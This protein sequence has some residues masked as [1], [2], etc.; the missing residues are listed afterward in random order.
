MLKWRGFECARSSAIKCRRCR[1]A[2]RPIAASLTVT[3]NASNTCTL[4]SQQ[5]AEVRHQLL[6]SSL[7]NGDQMLVSILLCLHQFNHSSFGCH[8]IARAP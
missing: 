7:G 5:Q 8:R 6:E 2:S 1:S 4:R 3:P